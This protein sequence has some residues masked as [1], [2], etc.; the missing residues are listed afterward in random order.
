MLMVFWNSRPI[1]FLMCLI[2]FNSVYANEYE[3]R[4]KQVDT[5]LQN[6]EYVLAADL[7]YHFSEQATEALKNGVPLFWNIKIKVKKRRN[8]WFDKTEEKH[9]IRYRLQYHALL[10]MYRVRNENTHIVSNFSTLTAALD[11][12]AT[13]RNLPVIQKSK[14]LPNALY[15]VDIKIDFEDSELPLPLQTQVILNSQW[16]L[17]SNWTQWTLSNETH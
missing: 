6:D 5:M 8:F 4:V 3:T 1:F 2:F 10:K 12:M 15:L 11:G 9:E 14:L 13:I 17:S 16:Q 7:D